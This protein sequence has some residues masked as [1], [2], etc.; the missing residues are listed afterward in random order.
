MRSI[1]V[2]ISVCLAS[3]TA[4]THRGGQCRGQTTI[5]IAGAALRQTV[6]GFKTGGGPKKPPHVDLFRQ[7]PGGENEMDTF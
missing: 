4:T 7:T 3:F 1:R 2:P 6:P 5:D